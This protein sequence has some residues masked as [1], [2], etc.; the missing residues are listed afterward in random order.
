MLGGKKKLNYKSST[1]SNICTYLFKM[2][3]A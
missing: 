2:F 3:S 1:N